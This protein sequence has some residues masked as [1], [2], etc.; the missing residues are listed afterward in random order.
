[1][2]KVDK[3]VTIP[4][5]EGSNAFV[6]GSCNAA[7]AAPATGPLAADRVGS[8]LNQTSQAASS[9]VPASSMQASRKLNGTFLARLA[10]ISSSDGQ[11]HPRASSGWLPIKQA[12]AGGPHTCAAPA[13]SFVMHLMMSTSTVC[14]PLW[15]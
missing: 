8:S 1:M 9:G 5:A 4:S 2:R 14:I 15:Q 7:A 12:S 10:S 13:C 3:P 6:F 11:P